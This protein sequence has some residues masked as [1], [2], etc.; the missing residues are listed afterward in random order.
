MRSGE[1]WKGHGSVLIMPSFC[2]HLTDEVKE[3]TRKVA[4]TE[5]LI[6]GGC[7]PASQTLAFGV[8]TPLKNTACGL[9]RRRMKLRRYDTANMPPPSKQPTVDLIPACINNARKC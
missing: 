5:A 4:A 3:G 9:S 8:N 6:P 1:V 2:G 7:R